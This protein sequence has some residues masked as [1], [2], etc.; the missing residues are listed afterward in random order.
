M[1]YCFSVGYNSCCECY[2]ALNFLC[3]F[4]YTSKYCDHH[5][6]I[7]DEKYCSS[8]MYQFRKVH[9]F[10]C[11]MCHVVGS[12]VFFDSFLSYSFLSSHNGKGTYTECS[13]PRTSYMT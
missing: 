3:I 2:V 4:L 1:K 8:T 12:P 7:M 13:S 10:C 5:P 9:V 11:F 6:E